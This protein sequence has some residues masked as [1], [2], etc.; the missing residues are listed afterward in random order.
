MAGWWIFLS[1]T[2]FEQHLP[3]LANRVTGNTVCAASW[4]R[5]SADTQPGAIISSA[6]TDEVLCV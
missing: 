4:S 1:G 5:R 6:P 2:E 3:A